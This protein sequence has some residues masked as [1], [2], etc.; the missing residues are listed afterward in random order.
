MIE[1][2]EV[3]LLWFSNDMLVYR[4]NPKKSTDKLFQLEFREVIEN[5]VKI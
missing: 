4:E 1:E 3:K 5:K 2:E